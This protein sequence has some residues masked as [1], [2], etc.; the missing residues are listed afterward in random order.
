[1]FWLSALSCNHALLEFSYMSSCPIRPR[2]ILRVTL[3]LVTTVFPLL[4]IVLGGTE[5]LSWIQVYFGTQDYYVDHWSL[6]SATWFLLVGMLGMLP[7][8]R[9][10]FQRQARLWWLW[11]SML[12]PLFNIVYINFLLF[13]HGHG[14][15]SVFSGDYAANVVHVRLAQLAGEVRQAT[16]Q[17]KPWHCASG[18]TTT[19]SPYNRAG[20]RLFYQQVCVAADH[21]TEESLLASSAPGTIYIATSPDEKVVWLMATVLPGSKSHTVRW[22]RGS[23][24]KPFVLTDF[25]L[26]E[27][28][29]MRA[30][31]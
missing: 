30:N 23:S 5:F 24:G 6:R 3:A 17:G 1:M 16:E 27:W 9:V 8:V 12:V 22:L 15:G 29:H 18:P 11:L 28:G 2:T 4:S 31:W 20:E 14:H 26:S 7:A 25:S 13:G 10:L 21:P 19:L